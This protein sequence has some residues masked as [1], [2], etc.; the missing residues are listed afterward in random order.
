MHLNPW[1]SAVLKINQLSRWITDFWRWLAEGKIVLMCILVLIAVATLGIVTW[2]SETS[3][4]VAGYV[5]QFIGMIFAIRGLL[6]VR[7]Y[8]GQPLLRQL[9]LDWLKRFPKWKR[10]AVIGS[11]RVV[12]VGHGSLIVRGGV[13]SPDNP[14]QPIE[15]RIEGILNNLEQIRKAQ[16]AHD[17]AIEELRDRHEEHKKN[18]KQENKNMEKKIRSDLEYL[19][20]SDIIT[21]LVGLIWLTVGISMSTMALELSKWI[22]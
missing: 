20:T 16:R 10:D 19:H 3:I 22:Q 15:K 8:F 9:F 6:G 17:G 21:S 1:G 5:L 4:R 7:A 12:M 2:H 11:S 14:D 13:W 18:V